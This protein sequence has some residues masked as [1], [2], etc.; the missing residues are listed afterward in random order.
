MPTY[1]RIAIMGNELWARRDGPDENYIAILDVPDG[2]GVTVHSF[3]PI[4][5]TQA[6]ARVS[7]VEFIEQYNEG[8]DD[9]PADPD[10]QGTPEDLE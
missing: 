10:A 8:D 4:D 5:D 3:D 2:A 6:V 1:N 9:V 7:I